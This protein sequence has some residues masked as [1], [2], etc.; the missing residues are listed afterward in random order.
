MTQLT[1]GQLEI[2]CQVG[3]GGV[4]FTFIVREHRLQSSGEALSR[5]PGSGKLTNWP[6]IVLLQHPTLWDLETDADKHHDPD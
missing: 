2:S 6:P 3:G 1:R 5:A 4:G